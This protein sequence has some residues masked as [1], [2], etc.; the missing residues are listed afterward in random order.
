MCSLHLLQWIQLQLTS[1]YSRPYFWSWFGHHAFKGVTR[2]K[3]SWDHSRLNLRQNLFILSFKMD[4]C[5]ACMRCL[6][7]F[8]CLVEYIMSGPMTQ[9]PGT[10]TLSQGR[11]VYTPSPFFFFIV[12][13]RPVHKSPLWHSRKEQI[14]LCDISIY[15]LLPPHASYGLLMTL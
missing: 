10:T 8:A 12:W 5:G 7:W 11:A 15:K 6:I 14:S 9:A 4:C 13:D 3:I 1:S 2:V